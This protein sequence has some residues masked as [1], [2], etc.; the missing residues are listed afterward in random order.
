MHPRRT[1]VN[2]SCGDSVSGGDLNA[3]LWRRALRHNIN[4]AH[5]QVPDFRHVRWRR[6]KIQVIS[7]PEPALLMTGRTRGEQ[8]R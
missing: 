6:K 5:H 4:L 8:N 3:A 1:R 2:A 7:H